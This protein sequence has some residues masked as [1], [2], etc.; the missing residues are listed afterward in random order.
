MNERTLI[1]VSHLSVSYDGSRRILNDLSFSLEEND[2]L[3]VVGPNGG[4]KTTL[5]KVLLG[6]LTPLEGELRFFSKGLR[7]PSLRMGY[8]PQMNRI[9]KKFPISVREVIASGLMAVKPRFRSFNLEQKGRIDEMLCQMGLEALG[10]RP[11]GEL[12]GGQIQRA[13]LGRA[14]VS[15]PQVLVLDE[16]SS[17]IDRAFESRF[18]RMLEEAN[19]SSAILM[20]SHD[21]EAVG[22]LAKR[23]LFIDGGLSETH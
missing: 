16:P 21:L 1:E 10:G 5:L 15:R 13:L 11:I 2:F 8:L 20:V 9:D 19:R 23:R 22:R 6:L 4:G 12:S 17:Y 18:F 14:L 3:V 7:V